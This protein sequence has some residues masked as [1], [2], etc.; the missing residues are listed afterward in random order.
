MPKDNGGWSSKGVEVQCPKC[1]EVGR[2]IETTIYGRT[3]LRP[4]EHF[5]NTCSHDWDGGGMYERN[6]DEQDD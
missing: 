4:I 5:C 2:M 6:D 3:A 1:G